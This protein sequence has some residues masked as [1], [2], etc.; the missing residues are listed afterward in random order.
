MVCMVESSRVE[1]SVCTPYWY[2]VCRYWTSAGTN[3]TKLVLGQ[4]S[5][6]AVDYQNVFFRV[7][8]VDSRFEGALRSTLRRFAKEALVTTRRL[9]ASLAR[10]V[11]NQRPRNTN[12]RIGAALTAAAILHISGLSEAALPAHPTHG[13]C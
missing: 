6:R 7:H 5:V 11:S 12:M 3:G 8:V 13:N 10:C 4:C 9:F 2:W 1:P